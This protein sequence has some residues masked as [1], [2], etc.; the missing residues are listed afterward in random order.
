MRTIRDGN[1]ITIILYDDASKNP[2][3]VI[4]HNNG[5]S[6]RPMRQIDQLLLTES[7]KIWLSSKM[8]YI[9]SWY[10]GVLKN[11]KAI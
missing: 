1:R 6:K 9:I 3:I 11:A 2:E 10:K 8:P 7:E 5:K 4:D